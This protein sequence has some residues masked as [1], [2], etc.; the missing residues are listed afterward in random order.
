MYE[1]KKHSRNVLLVVVLIVHGGMDRTYMVPKARQTA[2]QPI[3]VPI[4]PNMHATS[5]F[6]LRRLIDTG[7]DSP[8]PGSFVPSGNS[9]RSSGLVPSSCLPGGMKQFG[10]P[11]L[12]WMA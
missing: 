3:P 8:I 4:P 12:G 6:S 10:F 2:V 1:E 9:S 11:V 5:P 7:H